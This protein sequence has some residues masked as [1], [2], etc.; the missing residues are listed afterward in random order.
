[1]SLWSLKCSGVNLHGTLWYNLTFAVDCYKDINNE[2]QRQLEL[3]R[4]KKNDN[5][6]RLTSRMKNNKWVF[7][8]E[9]LLP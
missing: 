2:L 7:V 1:M 4:G 5:E 6:M 8:L 9:T 3:I